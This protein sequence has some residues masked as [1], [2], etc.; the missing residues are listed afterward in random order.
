MAVRRQLLEIRGIELHFET[1]PIAW[2]DGLLEGTAAVYAAGDCTQFPLK[3]GGI[4]T[5]QADAVATAIA[6]DVGA[7][8]ESPPVS[9]VIRGLLLTGL[10]PRYLRSDIST[11]QSVVDTEPL[12]WPPAK[13]VGR[14]LTTPDVRAVH[15][16]LEMTTAPCP[17]RFSSEIG[18]APTRNAPGAGPACAAASSSARPSTCGA[19]QR[20][21]E[22]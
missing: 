1:A 13:I 3:Q 2:H 18:P 21:R 11:G 22:R 19:G 6:A 17:G 20:K 16:N 14:Y 12:L 7:V 10:T 4:A 15:T 8:S 5:Q 9:P